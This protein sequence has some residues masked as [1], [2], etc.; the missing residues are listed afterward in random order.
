MT[1]LPIN[2]TQAN[3]ASLGKGLSHPGV[4]VGLAVVLA[5]LVAG[6]SLLLTH[7]IGND[8]EA[9]I[10]W[11]REAAGPG[12]LQTSGPSWKP[13]PVI[14]IAP[15]TLFTRG[16]AD[17]Y[18]WLLVA[19]A[20]AV[21]A[22]LGAASLARRAGGPAAAVLTALLIV[23][24]PWWFYNAILG[25][26]EPLMVALIIGAVLAY[27]AGYEAF[28]SLSLGLAALVRPE[29]IPLALLFGA[30][31]VLT[32]PRR[33]QRAVLFTAGAGLVLLGWL[34]PSIIHSGL[35]A[36][37]VARASRPTAGAA[38]NAA[39]PFLAVF[40]NTFTELTPL[41]G[42]L[43]GATVVMML[44]SLLRG[45]RTGVGDVIGGLSRRPATAAA[46]FGLAWVMVVAVMAQA[47]FPGNSRYLIPGLAALVLCAALEATRL[48]AGALWR[49]AL[50]VTVISASTF[51]ISVHTL[52]LQVEAA[53]AHTR[54]VALMRREI[55]ETPCSGYRVTF[56]GDVTTLAQVTDQSIAQTTPPKDMRLPGGRLVVCNPDRHTEG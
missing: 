48:A 1:S 29:L 14:L 52:H 31:C 25:D 21:L 17:V 45:V 36:S 15:F 40:K 4:R 22:V 49:G 20:G 27:E 28:G 50:V 18:W 37:T 51:A 3:A 53:S 5:L 11:A 38:K 8:P 13:L 47:G 55:T 30:W 9:W 44:G 56:A 6:I 12:I 10:V 33:R 2:S 16:E 32:G 23:L 39:I 34:V 24:S 26:A 41:P 19:R 35:G 42:I 43:V 54:E 7:A 46:L